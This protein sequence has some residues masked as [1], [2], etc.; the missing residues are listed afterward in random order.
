MTTTLSPRA[1]PAARRASALY[2]AAQGSGMPLLLV[3]GLGVSGAVFEP[4]LPALSARYQTL[5]PDLRGHGRSRRLPGP[6]TLE[7]QAADLENL[8]DLLAIPSCYVLG[9]ASGGAV[10][11]EFAHRHPRRVRGMA[12]V[13]AQ[14][15][16]TASIRE[17]IERRLRPEL[18]RLLGSGGMGR[19]AAH[20]GCPRGTPAEAYDFVRDT[21]ASNDGRRVAPLARSLQAFDSRPWLHEI[22]CPALVIGGAADPTTPVQH[23]RELAAALPNAELHVIPGAGHWLVKTHTMQL[24]EL[25]TTWLDRQEACA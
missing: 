19:L 8:L 14:A 24:L 6:D 20:T 9:Y 25:L 1:I 17:Q 21:M 13:C 16:S 15:H 4:L 7:C 12:L 5:V 2:C 22:A 23:A 10:V 3:H 11:Q 18:F